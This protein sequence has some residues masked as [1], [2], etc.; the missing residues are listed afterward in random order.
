MLDIGIYLEEEVAHWVD[1]KDGARFKLKPLTAKKMNAIR[2]QCQSKTG[3]RR[4]SVADFDEIKF[5][6]I[7]AKRT[8]EDWEGINAGGKP[9]ECT[10]DNKIVLIEC[11]ADISKFVQSASMNLGDYVEQEEKKKIKN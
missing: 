1:Y 2:M 9:F 3:T 8:I 5:N 6:R 11:N 4:Q 7:L 10:D